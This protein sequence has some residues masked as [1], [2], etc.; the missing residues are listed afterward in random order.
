MT[1]RPNLEDLDWAEVLELAID[2]RLAA[3]RTTIPAE[4]VSYDHDEQRATVQPTVRFSRRNPE[5]WT[6]ETYRPEPVPNCPV[7]F[8]SGG[9]FS[10]TFPLEP[11]DPVKLSV[12]DRSLDEWLTDSSGDA[13]PADPRRFDLQDAIVEPGLR[14]FAQALADDRIDDGALV[15]GGDEVHLGSAKPGDS[16]AVA[17]DVEARL[18]AI[19]QVVNTHILNVL[20]HLTPLIPLPPVQTNTVSPTTKPGD[21]ASSTVKLEK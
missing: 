15:I 1:E 14:S 11:G 13:E 4:V 5:D 16:A 10:I 6:R 21:T 2:S 9:G 3:V 18:Q 8:P 20:A 19:E 7:L 12:A 17:S